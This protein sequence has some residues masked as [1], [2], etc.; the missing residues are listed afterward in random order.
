MREKPIIMP[1][2]VPNTTA[3][4]RPSTVRHRVCQ[5]ISTNSQRNFQKAGGR[6]D[7]EA[8]L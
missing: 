1:I 3:R 7:G 6:S 2:S 5:P 4:P 8:I